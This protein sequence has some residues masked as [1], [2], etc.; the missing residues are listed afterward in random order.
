MS[1]KDYSDLLQ[2]SSGVYILRLNEV[3]GGVEIT[4]TRRAQHILISA[5][6][7]LEIARAKKIASRLKAQIVAGA[8]FGN[9]AKYYSD[10]S[11]SAAKGGDLDWVRKGQTVPNFEST[12]FAMTE[13]QISEPVVTNFGVHIIK[14]NEISRSSDPKEQMKAVAYNNL[15]SQKVDQYYPIFLSKLV[16]RAYIKY[17]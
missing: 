16:G 7:E 1:P 15:M 14:L 17:L 8:D 4:E 6:S 3:I 9:V 2:T 13:G 10:D 12:L 11:S 5:E